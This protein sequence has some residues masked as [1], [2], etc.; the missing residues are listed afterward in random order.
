MM[1]NSPELSKP[2]QIEK[3]LTE[4][5]W[6]HIDSQRLQQVIWNLVLNAFQE[7]EN[8]GRIS[9]STAVHTDRRTEIT[10]MKLAEI[11][12]SDSGPGIVP[13]NQGK[14]FDP[15]FTTKEQGTGL[16]L[17]IVHRI[18]EDYGGE[19]FLESNGGSGTTFTIRF[20]LAEEDQHNQLR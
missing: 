16:G 15:F 13:E 8:S 5:L 2:I 18:V 11:S 14:I 1:K 10:P 6:V 20:P 7:M 3:D 4:D 9:I 19:I 12:I 17:T